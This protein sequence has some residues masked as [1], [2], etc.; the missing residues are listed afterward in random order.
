MGYI[1]FSPLRP[2][3]TQPRKQS[4]MAITR[5]KGTADVLPSVAGHRAVKPS[6][7]DKLELL[8]LGLLCQDP[9]P[10]LG[11]DRANET[12]PTGLRRPPLDLSQ[13]SVPLCLATH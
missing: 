13:D 1:V 9:S 7:V 12:D 6:Y 3:L 8:F 4:V 2:L 10:S 11:K 5:G